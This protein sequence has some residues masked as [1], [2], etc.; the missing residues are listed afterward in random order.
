MTKET[1]AD[2]NKDES[3]V[4]DVDTA[5]VD[6]PK[7]SSKAI[8]LKELDPREYD[9]DLIDEF[10][11]VVFHSGLDEK[12]KESILTW[13]VKPGMTPMYPRSDEVLLNA[14]ERT[15]SPFALYFGTS[16][17]TPDP[18]ENTLYNRKT[19]FSRLHVV[20]LDDIGTKVDP[21]SLPDDL[22]PTY[23]MESSK[24]NFQW[25]FVLEEPVDLLPAA[26]ALIQLVYESGYSDEGGK[27]P[28]K[29]VRLPEGVNGKK[30]DKMGFVSKLHTMD[31]PYWE[32]QQLLDALGVAVK[33][34]DVIEDAEAVMRKRST[35]KLGTGVWSPVK[36]IS[37]SLDGII[38]PV[39]EWLYENDM[40]VNESGE[41]V[42]IRCPWGDLHSSGA[43][44]AGYKPVG[45]GNDTTRRGYHCFHDSCASRNTLDFLNFVA[46]NGGPEASFIDHAA[47][48]VS[49]WVYDANDNLAWQVKG[50]KNPMPVPLLGFNNAFA[51]YSINQVKSDGKTKNVKE[52]AMWLTSPA[53]LTVYGSTFDP[54]T[55]AKFVEHNGVLRINRYTKP[56]FPELPINMDH[57]DRFLDFVEYLVPNEEDREYFLDWVIAK[58][59]DPSFRGP[60]I[61][62]TTPIQGTG[63]TTLGDMISTLIGKSNAENVPFEDIISPN[64]SYNEWME[65]P[66]VVSDETLTTRDSDFYKS[67]EKL[68]RLI[69]PRPKK[70][71]INPKYGKQRD[72]V[73][74]YSSFLFMANH[75]GAAIVSDEDRRFY[76]IA[77]TMQRE[78]PEFFTGLNNW[79]NTLDNQGVPIWATHVYNWM[80]QQTPD[81][82]KLYEPPQMNAAKEAMMSA[83]KSPLEIG[84]DTVLQVC[85]PYLSITQFKQCIDSIAIRLNLED[86]NHADRAIDRMFKN[87]TL[88]F[89]AAAKMAIKAGGKTHRPR[90]VISAISKDTNVI[91]PLTDMDLSST[92]RDVIARAMQEFDLEKKVVEINE[93]LDSLEV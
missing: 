9:T 78:T 4:Q 92:D 38:D 55:P 60:A 46:V 88:G 76:V 59:Q 41:W 1:K 21:K 43:D 25:G 81:M 39:L 57:V 90:V 66:L 73:M 93:A 2:D 72:D 54:S 52:T 15:R 3:E 22:E 87:S 61:I 16:T 53:R 42:T 49:E 77:N 45:R 17:C 27:M 50:V 24:G 47:K 63:R 14:L 36:S 20:V 67:Y 11:S 89:P 71:R 58:V 28:T 80:Q 85:G 82:N 65:R 32:P 91:S 18:V 29:L 84:V 8:K 68:K 23:I 75:I 70:T 5:V 6:V 12:A 30:G 26:E 33:W 31:G 79:L 56:E 64:N 44:T 13:S 51:Q 35:E 62:M 83:T 34:A 10:L 74:C 37:P 48:L 19:L 86:L 7:V 40:V 69:D